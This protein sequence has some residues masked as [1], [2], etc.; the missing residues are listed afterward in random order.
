MG[1]DRKVLLRMQAQKLEEIESKFPLINGKEMGKMHMMDFGKG[2]DG[3]KR[4]CAMMKVNAGFRWTE[5]MPK[6][7]GGP[8]PEGVKCC[9]KT[10][11]GF[12]VSGKVKTT[13][14]ETGE[15]KVFEPGMAYYIEPGHDTEVLEDCVMV[16]FESSAAEFYGTINEKN[17]ASVGN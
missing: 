12:L 15:S 6:D 5:C 16:E 7:K 8:M 2:S 9:P 10:H 3:V 11:F 1:S 17:A 4:T 14:V 13:M